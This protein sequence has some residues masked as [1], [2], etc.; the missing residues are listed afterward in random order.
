MHSFIAPSFIWNTEHDHTLQITCTSIFYSSRLIVWYKQLTGVFPTQRITGSVPNPVCEFVHGFVDLMRF[1][2][3]VKV[4]M[5][6]CN[7][8]CEVHHYYSPQCVCQSG[9]SF[10]PP[11][12]SMTKWRSKLLQTSLF[13]CFFSLFEVSCCGVLKRPSELHFQT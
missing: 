1:D 9:N 12:G 10:Q 11:M 8:T 3:T 2:E 4:L 13:T 5:D 6:T 7:G